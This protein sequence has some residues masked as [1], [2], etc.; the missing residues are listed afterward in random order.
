MPNYNIPNNG[1]IRSKVITARI[2][3]G[4]SYSAIT[5][6]YGVP[7]STAQD[8]VRKYASGMEVNSLEESAPVTQGFVVEGYQRDKPK[9]FKKN[10]DEILNFLEQLSPIHIQPKITKA[11]TSVSLNDYAVVGS[12]FH[13]GCHDPRAIDIFLTTIDEL[14]PKIIVLNGDTMDMLAIS[15]YPKDIKKSWSLLDERIAYHQ[16][17]DDLIDVS[18]GAEIFETVSNHSGQSIDGRWR[19]YL[20]ER[21]GELGSLPNITDML[22]YQNIFMGE[23]QKYVSHVDF[24]ELNG[25]IVTHGTTVRKNGGYSARGEIEKWGSSILHGHTHRIGSTCQRIPAIGNRPESQ[26]YGFEGGCLCS[27]NAAY[28]TS[29]NW[30]QGFS[31]VSLDDA[32]NTFGL[33]QVMINNGIANITTLGCSI[34]S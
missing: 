5:N 16:F 9:K 14:K 8:W 30:Q 22:S 33:E 6:I 24:V 1:D 20:S 23:Y 18:G 7:K 25:L 27:L 32:S 28:G 34:K 3:D 31:I 15:R 13:F 29:F 17:L 26:I 21:L 11:S 10:E 2:N 12:D 19:R 4:L